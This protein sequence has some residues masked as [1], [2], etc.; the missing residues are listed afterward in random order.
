M[1]FLIFE[2]HPGIS[3]VITGLGTVVCPP[4]GKPLIFKSAHHVTCTFMTVLIL[5]EALADLESL[6]GTFN[7]LHERMAELQMVIKMGT[8]TTWIAS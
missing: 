3:N 2:L 8:Q 6:E 4:L 7:S 5:Q 1:A